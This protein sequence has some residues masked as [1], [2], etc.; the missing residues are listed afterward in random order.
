ML[1]VTADL[2]GRNWKA[3]V[4]VTV[5]DSTLHPLLQLL[6][7]LLL[8]LG[9]PVA[10]ELLVPASWLALALLLRQAKLTRVASWVLRCWISTRARP[11]AGYAACCGGTSGSCTD[12][13]VLGGCGCTGTARAATGT[14]TCKFQGVRM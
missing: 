12:S 3:V 9:R 5:G 14:N 4:A 10:A 6:L 8:L 11:A 13:G 1:Y 7:R 2:L